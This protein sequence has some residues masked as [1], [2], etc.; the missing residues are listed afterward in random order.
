MID[1][2]LIIAISAVIMQSCGGS[3]PSVDA[4]P[5]VMSQR[6]VLLRAP[7][8]FPSDAVSMHKYSAILAATEP[9]RQLCIN[10]IRKS[11]NP[12][13]RATKGLFGKS[14]LTQ[15]IE[16]RAKNMPIDVALT[17]FEMRVQSIAG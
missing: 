14:I 13:S 3:L 11:L 5:A 9:F 6:D 4:G 16:E 2:I 17:R 7:S 8:V 15:G 1:V 10:Q 12:V